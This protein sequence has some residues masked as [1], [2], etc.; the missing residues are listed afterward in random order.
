MSEPVNIPERVTQLEDEVAKVWYLARKADKDGSDVRAALGG[1]IG[2]LNAIGETQREH[3]MRLAEH[4][5]RL[6]RLERKVDNGFNE[7][8]K[9]MREGFSNVKV[10]Q[11][12]ITTLLNTI[13]EKPD[14]TD[15]SSEGAGG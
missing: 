15:T 8:R 2:V 1:Q 6:E 4:G 13:L 7:M 12:Q 5:K 3:G 9:E 11:V 14:E 10:G